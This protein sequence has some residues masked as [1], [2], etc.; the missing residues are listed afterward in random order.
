[1]KQNKNDRSISSIIAILLVGGLMVVGIVFLKTAVP[2]SAFHNKAMVDSLL[3]I[4]IPDTAAPA[5]ILPL[6]PETVS[7]ALPDTIGKD[8]R[9]ADEAGYEDGYNGGREDRRNK[10]PRVSYDESSTFPTPRERQAYAEA[11][12]RGYEHGLAGKA[13]APNKE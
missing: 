13:Q 11:Y 7:V 9:P 3:T 6:Q 4:A 10:T 2:N 8:K 5:D 1:M 12:H